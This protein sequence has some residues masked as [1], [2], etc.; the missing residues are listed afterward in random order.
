MCFQS[1]VD[2]KKLLPAGIL[3]DPLA[4]GISRVYN[5]KNGKIVTAPSGNKVIRT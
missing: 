4:T 5:I 3:T 1:N 2:V